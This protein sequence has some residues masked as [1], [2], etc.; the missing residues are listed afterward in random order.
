MTTSWRTRQRG[1][2]LVTAIFVLVVLAALGAAI[3]VVSP[4]Q[5][6]GSALDVQGARAYQAARAGLE[7]GLFQVTRDADYAAMMA[8]PP[9]GANALHWCSSTD[10][11]TPTV[12]SF[13]F[14]AATLS[15]FTVTVECY[16]VADGSGGPWV[17]HIQATAC[18][19][20]AA[21]W[22]ATS[23]ACPG[24]AGMTYVERRVRVTI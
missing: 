10:A 14:T 1:F 15:A 6:L 12:A 20:P 3:A 21:G 19:Q 23:V 17:F 13:G 8:V 24:T 9:P 7:W 5:Q 11:G 16:G 18:N 2:T 22:V 4:G